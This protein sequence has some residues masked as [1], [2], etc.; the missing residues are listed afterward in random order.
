MK[1]GNRKLFVTVFCQLMNIEEMMELEN[2]DFDN[3]IDKESIQQHQWVL[4]QVS[5]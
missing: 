4:K 5:R 3:H 2:N 1:K